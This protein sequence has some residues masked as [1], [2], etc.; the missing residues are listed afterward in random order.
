L[1]Y[2]GLDDDRAPAPGGRLVLR[3]AR[4]LDE[5]A[6][7]LRI[8]KEAA[9][10]RLEASMRKLRD[11]RE[12]RRKPR[13]DTAILTD[14]NALMI[15][16]SLLAADAL[17]DERVRGRA[18]RALDFVRVNLRAPDGG[19]YH[20]YSGANAS[21]P[22]LAADQVYMLAALL[23]AY[24]A[25]GREVYLEEAR[26]LVRLIAEHHLDPS[27]GLLVN[28]T[29]LAPGTELARGVPMLAVMYDQPMPSPQ[30]TLARALFVLHGISSETRYERDARR[31]LQPA[32]K[33]VGMSSA[34]GLGA[35][36][37]VLELSARGDAVIVIVGAAGDP[38]TNAL[39]ERARRSYRPGKV[40][41]ALDA[42]DADS[43]PAPARAMFAAT[44][45]REVPLAF[46]CAGTACAHPAESADALAA[47][48]A[49]FG[50]EKVRVPL[51]ARRAPTTSP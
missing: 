37:D 13:I 33:V 35:L 7:R 46:V 45:D 39:L 15:S 43:L 30:A 14:R 32:R 2:F 10:S 24:Q 11:L 49:T 36:A 19:F 20:V 50:V 17:G 22:G 12:R 38:R 29:P 31:V 23:D 28:R 40:V 26:S 3:R 18:L 5:V 47:T 1:L 25:S 51:A 34:A 21:L 27:T 41:V 42:A 9:K 8:S 6:A 16:A 48:I 44:R 4:S